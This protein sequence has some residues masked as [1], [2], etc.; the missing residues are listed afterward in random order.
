MHPVRHVGRQ[1][2]DRVD[3]MR[4]L[5]HVDVVE[6]EDRRSRHRVE[7]FPQP[8]NRRGDHRHPDRRWDVED[9]RVDRSHVVE[10]SGDRGQEDGRVVVS[11]IERQPSERPSIFRGPLRKECGLPV[12]RGS[13]DRYQRDAARCLELGNQI[14][15]RD[16]TLAANGRSVELRLR[17]PGAAPGEQ[18]RVGK[19]DGRCAMPLSS[20]RR[21][22]D[23]DASL[24]PPRIPQGRLLRSI[25]FVQVG[26]RGPTACSSRASTAVRSTVAERR[27]GARNLYPTSMGWARS[28]DRSRAWITRVEWEVLHEAASLANER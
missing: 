4:V 20:P 22:T 18:G 5:E 19:T 27:R 13:H 1:H 15:P 11:V 16:E 24:A 2:L 12:S 8:V 28:S 3:A 23:V 21:V 17:E 6:D 7:H 26:W 9:R 10:G 14:R 25:V